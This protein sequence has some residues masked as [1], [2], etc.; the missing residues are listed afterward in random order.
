MFLLLGVGVAVAE[1]VE[2]DALVGQGVAVGGCRQEQ[3]LEI[4]DAEPEH[5]ETKV[6][7]PV[8]AVLVVEV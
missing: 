7:R 6:G 1:V 8:V 3:A 4:L 2:A 5:C